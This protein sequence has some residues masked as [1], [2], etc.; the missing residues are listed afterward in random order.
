VDENGEVSPGGSH[1]LRHEPREREWEG[2]AGDQLL[3]ESIDA[4]LDR[5]FGDEGRLVLHEV[6]S[7]LIHLDVHVVPPGDDRPWITLVTSGMAERSM[8][9]PEGLEEHAYAELMLA[10]PPDWPLELAPGAVPEA[11]PDDPP[12]Y[13]PVRLLKTLG[14]LPHEYDTFLYWGHSIPNGDPPEP[15]AASTSLSGALIM[16]PLLV[17]E[18]FAEL[19]LPDGR[20]VHF[21]AVVAMHA[22]EMELKLRR[23]ADH[24]AEL[25]DDAGVS[26]LVDPARP[27][28]V[29]K[30]RFFGRR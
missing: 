24:L 13:W 1:I 26:E 12:G 6:A 10:L 27:S 15:Y 19:E 18:D 4:H 3:L 11:E 29:V 25:F 20:T 7:D 30:R 2:T 17:P 28:V 16:P 8:S 14:R 9:V 21:Y 5:H 23:G 22:D